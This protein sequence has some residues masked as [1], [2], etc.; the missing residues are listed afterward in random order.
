MGLL[1]NSRQ[2]NENDIEMI[3]LVKK[4]KTIRAV[5][6][7]FVYFWKIYL[8]TQSVSEVNCQIEFLKA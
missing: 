2:K 5:I 8:K 6:H 4:T 1:E 3:L 7:Y